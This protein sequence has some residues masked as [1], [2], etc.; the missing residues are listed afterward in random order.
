MSQFSKESVL[1]LVAAISLAAFAL[2]RFL[3]KDERPEPDQVSRIA[4]VQMERAMRALREE[5]VSRGH[6]FD[7]TLDP[8]HTGLIGVEYSEMVTTLG[9]VEAKRSTTNPNF[10]GAIVRMLDE[11]G[12]VRGDTIAVGCS[13]SFP[14]LAVATLCAARA[15]GVHPEVIVSLG[16]SSYGAN[17][18][19]WTLIDILEVLH[20]NGFI[21]LRPAAVSLGGAD[22]VG[23][24][25]EPDTRNSL[26]DKIRSSGLSFLHEPDLQRNVAKR[27]AIYSGPNGA[28][29]LAAFVNIGGNYADLG[30]DPIVLKLEPGVNRQIAMPVKEERSGVVFA[31][32]KRHIPVIH[33]LHIKGL[34]LKYGLPWDPTPLP[35]ADGAEVSHSH[36]AP[37]A[38]VIA[39]TVFYFSSVILIFIVHRKKFFR[40]LP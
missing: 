12:V 17:R 38:M 19:N 37:G 1:V 23:N 7:Q 26:R 21:D 13:G 4:S 11:A 33:L 39:V 28:R 10:A 3:S 5:F 30:T 31:M 22:D 20:K 27:M 6:Q 32:A 24:E 36:S 9:S 14:S 35:S 8:N 15:L 40:T 34:V 2:V 29:T 25:F 16:S 18:T